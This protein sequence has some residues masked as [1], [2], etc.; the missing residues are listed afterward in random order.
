M[1]RDELPR[2]ETNRP[3]VLEER[4]RDLLVTAGLQEVMTYSLTTPEREAPL[5]GPGAEYVRIAN[6]IS[7]ERVVMRHSVLAS[8][9]EV[10]AANLRNVDALKLF[11]I[12][13]IYLPQKGEK[14]PAEPSRLALVLTGPRVPVTWADPTPSGAVD[15]FDLKGVVECLLGALHV[16]D[17]RYQPSKSGYLHPG[18]SADVFAGKQ[19]LGNFGQL[20]P[21]LSESFAL[22]RRDVFVGELDLEALLAVVPDRF[23]VAPIPAFPPALRDIAIVLDEQLPAAQVLAEIRAGGGE[24]LRDATLFDVYRGPNLPP[25]KKSLAY[26][27]TY[28]AD[29][30]TLTDKEVAKAHDKIVSRLARTLQAELRA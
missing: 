17:V 24:L 21:A 7:S 30:R 25:G 19:S 2:Q 23:K 20:H 10:A 1:L 15:F 16:A 13:Y 26:H 8:V 11:E 12:G 3:L 29:D 5:V 6:P 4:V 14:L 9:L 28:Q 22:G 27:L 18:K